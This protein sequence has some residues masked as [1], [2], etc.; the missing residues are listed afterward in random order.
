MRLKI[1][2]IGVL[3]VLLL[4]FSSSTPYRYTRKKATD[5]DLH[6]VTITEEGKISALL[7]CLAQDIKEQRGERLPF[8]FTYPFKNS[9]KTFEK[10]TDVTKT[11][12]SLF[13]SSKKRKN[14]KLFIRKTP[15]V[16]NL[17][18]T[19]DFQI[20]NMKINI[21]G[22][23]AT[24]K[25]NLIFYAAYPDTSDIEW[26][27]PGRRTKTKF[28]LVKDGNKWRISKVDKLFSFIEDVTEEQALRA[29]KISTGKSKQIHIRSKGGGRR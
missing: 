5:K 17:T 1:I 15:S 11:F 12:N 24:V 14:D 13:E 27:A 3:L 29:K 9:D 21:E 7:D 20:D 6:R 28:S 19:W 22:N 4:L 25:C 2:C 8:Y 10:A 18:S 16:D 26:K 23:R